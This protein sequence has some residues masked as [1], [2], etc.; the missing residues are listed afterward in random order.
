MTVSGVATFNPNAI[1]IV[2]Q[3]LKLM[4]VIAE[5]E[6]PNAGLVEDGLF[7]LNS[8]TKE[9]MASGIHIWTEEE[10]ILFCQPNQQRYL[11]GGT[12]PDHACDAYSYAQTVTTAAANSGATQIAVSSPLGIADTFQIGVQLSPSPGN[13][14]WTT[15][16]GSPSGGII[17]LTAPLTA[18]V[19]SG[20]LVFS[21]AVNIIRPLRIPFARRLS[22][23][24]AGSNSPPS[25][26]PM[27]IMSHSDYMDLPDK[28][29]T[30]TPT[31]FFYQPKL[32]QGSLYIWPTAA[33]ATSGIRFTWHRPIDDFVSNTDT[34]DFPQEWGITLIYN[35][36][37]DWAPQFDVP[38][39][40]F[41]MIKTVAEQKKAMVAAWDREP[42]PILF[43]VSY[44]ATTR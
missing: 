43:G 7:F 36:A 28:N 6:A 30:G 13:I 1:G 8:L 29:S 5:N 44:D 37:A 10:A 14:Q 33:D 24:G 20:A 31:Q 15:V 39:Q 23:A 34:P 42:E 4:G 17:T 18:N 9:L 12:T 27:I 35:L 38:P 3:T 16:S 19:A 32:A 22:W 2:T 11:I 21:Y 41:Q 40:R 25:E 26:I